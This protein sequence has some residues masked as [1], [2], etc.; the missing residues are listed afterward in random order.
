ME[1]KIN[2]VVNE[3]E[4]KQIRL[5]LLLRE[6]YVEK[7]LDDINTSDKITEL[8]NQLDDIADLR[9]KISNLEDKEYE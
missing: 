2:L 6:K 9:S 7:M 8:W 1:K 5:G 4:L 3:E